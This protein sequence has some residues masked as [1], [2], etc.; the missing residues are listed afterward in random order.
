ME[1]LLK[2]KKKDKDTFSHAQASEK[3]EQKV[4]T[5]FNEF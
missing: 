4:N 5:I 1:E 2:I 3:N